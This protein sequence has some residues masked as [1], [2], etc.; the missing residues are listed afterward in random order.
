MNLFTPVSAP[1]PQELFETLAQ[2]YGPFRLERI[3]SRQHASPPGFWYDQDGTE[4][5]LLL[6]GSAVLSLEQDDGQIRRQALVPGDFLEIPA[7]CRHRV[8]ETAPHEDTIWLALHASGLSPQAGESSTCHLP[9]APS[10]E[11]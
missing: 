7:H 11:R 8:E 6:R 4:W 5:V 1:L 3:V 10:R 9:P 2:G